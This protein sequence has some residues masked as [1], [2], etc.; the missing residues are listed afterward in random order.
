M[1]VILGDDTFRPDS[2]GTHVG[3]RIA[4]ITPGGPAE[5]AGIRAGD[6]ILSANG[7][8]LGRANRRELSP[9]D[10][11]V[12]IIG[13]LEEKTERSVAPAAV[14]IAL[15]RLEKKGL[16][17]S[18]MDV[19]TPE[20]GGRPRR[21]FKLSKAAFERLRESQKTSRL[22]SLKNTPRRLRLS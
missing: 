21:Y 4:G 18:R 2:T 16:V 6:V 15:R 3:V 8:A 14:Y 9:N 5:E 13:E 11:L 19:A 17:S 12:D 1:G 7:R 20:E 22:M 10:R